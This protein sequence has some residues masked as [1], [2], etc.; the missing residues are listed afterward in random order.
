MDI[1]TRIENLLKRVI[2]EDKELTRGDQLTNA[3]LDTPKSK[4]FGDY[5][6][7][8]AL[9]L[10]Q[11]LAK[12]P[13]EI[14]Q[15]LK[16]ALEKK[17]SCWSL[18]GEISKIEVAGAG[19]INFFLSKS[20]LYEIL[21]Q[22]RKRK[23]NF[24]T[25]K[26]G[27]GKKVHIEFVSANPTGPLNVAHG[28]QAAFGDTLAN[29]FQFLGYQVTREY[30]LN[31]EGV[32][33]DTL[34]DSLR[35]KYQQLLGISAEFPSSGY[36]G[37][38]IDDLASEFL[39]KYGN[40]FAKTDKKDRTFFSCFATSKILEGIKKD[41]AA[42]GVKFDSWFSQRQLNQT[43]K[44]KKALTLLK[45]KGYLYQ[46]EGAWWL[47]TTRF[48][49][50]KDRVVIKSDLSLTYIAPDI[51]Y[52]QTKFK[53]GFSQM[54]NIWGPDHHGY[55]A[56][57]KAAVSA[58][59]YDSEQLRVL[60]VQLVS[61]SSAEKIIPMSTRMG[62]FVSLHDIIEAVGKDAARF[63]FLMRKRDSHLHFDLELAKKQSLENP[64]YYIQYAHARISNILKF[65]KTAKT[66]NPSFNHKV[67]LS[68]L[69]KPE[70]LSLIQ[71]L[72]D[73]SSVIEFCVS[74]LEP[75]RMTVYLQDLAKEFHQYYEQ[76]KVVTEDLKLTCA[77]LVLIDAT[78]IV[79]K[80]GLRLLCIS[81]PEKM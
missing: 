77:R 71:S 81:A 13:L 19:F 41:L 79:L 31:D 64:V 22:I 27:S 12:P 47:A 61:L 45:V 5:S 38:Y 53:R 72:R 18:S 3:T 49:D 9:V 15:R 60:V 17:L 36:R 76:H 52:H 56:R 59:G 34:G 48:G 8:I 20:C 66:G 32:Q 67:D 44:I 28:R 75:H 63:F 35:A 30:Y 2:K 14:A 78:R 10:A 62:Q 57:L 58:L 23:D 26:T 7:N 74:N 40:R 4:K 25:A 21:L 73:F 43:G 51:A 16:E 11:R 39:Q 65:A 42:F 68:L 37:K 55:I 80:N 54:I 50:D 24:A 29:L 6:S 70:E 46:K 33:I 69:N 1:K